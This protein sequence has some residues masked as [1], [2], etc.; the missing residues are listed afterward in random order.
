MAFYTAD[1]FMPHATPVVRALTSAATQPTQPSLNAP[2]LVSPGGQSNINRFANSATHG[3]VNPD[4][5]AH[6]TG[7]PPVAAAQPTPPPAQHQA[8]YAAILAA[9]SKEPLSWGAPGTATGAGAFTS[10]T[11]WVH[12]NPE[13]EASGFKPYVPTPI[14]AGMPQSQVAAI[15]GE[16]P[17]QNNKYTYAAAPAGYTWGIGRTNM[18]DSGTTQPFTPE[19]LARAEAAGNVPVGTPLTAVAYSPGGGGA[20]DWSL[21]P[22]T[23]TPPMGQK[24]NL[25]SLDWINANSTY[26]NRIPITGQGLGP[27]AMPIIGYAPNPV[28]RNFTV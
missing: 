11:Y 14:T 13:D 4:S 10:P 12:S 25:N 16:G 2:T 8:T 5:V 3:W 26:G 20:N 9:L 23:V 22:Q 17:R 18:G 15:R 1:M 21:M 7:G 27:N 19:M 6:V 24:Y 28:T